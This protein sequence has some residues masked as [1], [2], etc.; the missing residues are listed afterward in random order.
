MASS[1]LER[2]VFLSR[3]RWKPSL[4]VWARWTRKTLLCWLNQYREILKYLEVF[5]AVIRSLQVERERSQTLDSVVA[6]TGRDVEVAHTKNVS[7]CSKWKACLHSFPCHECSCLSCA[8]VRANCKSCGV[9]FVVGR[10]EV[11]YFNGLRI[12][13]GGVYS[14]PSTQPPWFSSVNLAIYSWRPH[15]TVQVLELSFIFN[16]A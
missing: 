10:T 1:Q 7:A 5:N 6:F 2:G 12:V 4:R 14:K 13:C 15:V 16:C 8:T 11:Q 9:D 3:G